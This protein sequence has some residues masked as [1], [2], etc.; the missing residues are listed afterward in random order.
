MPSA[1]MQQHHIIKN[2]TCPHGAPLGA[3]P[4]C[5]GMGMGGGLKKADHTAKPGEMSWNECAAIGAMLKAQKQAKLDKQHDIQSFA[6][7]IA[8]FNSKIMNSINNL[9]KLSF[10]IQKNTPQ[11]ISKPV[12]FVISTLLIGSLKL[13]K[14]IAT[15]LNNT[16]TTANQKIADITNKITSVIGEIKTAIKQKLSKLSQSFKKKLKS[17]FSIFETTDTDNDDKK[18]EEAKKAFKLKT[19]IN[20]ILRREPKEHN[21]TKKGFEE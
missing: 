8:D 19:F 9:S 21:I 17:L 1:V 12:N 4:I 14:N 15:A 6:Q 7:K 20:K 11:I 13:I 16:V 10:V 2:G 18:I 3:C 5:N